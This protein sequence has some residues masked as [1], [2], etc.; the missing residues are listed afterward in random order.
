MKDTYRHKG[1]RKKLITSLKKR[2]IKNEQI[3]EAMSSIP[4]HFFLE[5]AFEE[6]AYQD[7]AFPID[8]GQTIS[9]P[10][11][12]A[13]Q[14]MLLELKKREKVME[15]GTGSGYQASVLAALGARVY[16][17]ERQQPLF[18]RAKKLLPLIGFPS[19]RLFFRD[20]Y[21]GLAEFAPFDKILVT[22]GA[23]KVP[24]LIK[25]QLKIGG[26]MVIPVGPDKVQEMLKITRISERK[27]ETVS[28][29]D[30]KFVPFAEGTKSG[31]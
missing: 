17:I 19:I 22:A 23:T 4:R 6:W 18:E 16:S 24:E 1:L 20:G 11:T 12:V 8:C 21:K 10:Y 31:K 29:G 7:K 15:I 25:K 30:F 2:G 9:Q 3:L 13:F 28:H 26:I 14:T 5:K 27:F